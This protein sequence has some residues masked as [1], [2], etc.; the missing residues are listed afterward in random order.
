MLELGLEAD[1]I[2]Q[3]AEGIILTQ[4]D[5]G[6]GLDQRI[7]RIGQAN[8]LERPPAQ[9]LVPALGHDLDWQTAIEIGHVFP[10]L[11]LGLGSVQQGLDKALILVLGHGTVDI[12]CLVAARAFLVIT[13]LTPG[14]VHIDTVGMD[15]R[16]NGIEKRQLPLAG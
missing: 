7:A 13:R 5:N 6:M 11:E 15:N 1:Q 12:G 16:G 10:F 8:R 2:I 3:G 14:N 9:G 4:L